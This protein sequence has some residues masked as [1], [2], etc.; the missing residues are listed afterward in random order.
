MEPG[1]ETV[2]SVDEQEL[3]EAM[4]AQIMGDAQEGDG[5]EE[6]EG[7]QHEELELD[8]LVLLAAVARTE[9]EGEDGGDDA[10]EEEGGPGQH[11]GERGGLVEAEHEQVEVEVAQCTVER[12]V[13][14]GLD[15][16]VTIGFG[17][18]GV[19][20]LGKLEEAFTGGWLVD[21]CSQECG[22]RIWCS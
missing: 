13:G 12:C 19:F 11:A 5:G 21:Q 22:L 8:D 14:A 7:G 10:D 17:K 1:H 15:W 9:K 3:A 16:S 2:E 4:L 18:E 6:R 20:H